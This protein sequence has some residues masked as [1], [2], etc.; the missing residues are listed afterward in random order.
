[1]Y[2]EFCQNDLL[3]KTQRSEVMACARVPLDEQQVTVPGPLG[4][5]RSLPALHPERK[6]ERCFVPYKPPPE[7]GSP[8][9]VEEFL[10]YAR[11]IIEDLEWLLALPHDKFWC[12]VVFDESLQSCLDSYLHHAPRSLDLAAL[13]SSPAVAEMQRSVHKVVFLTFLRM[14]T[15]KESKESFLTPSVFGE[16]IYENFLFD[17][18]KILDL[19]VLFG[20]GNS[21]LLHKM[22]DNI[23]TQQPSYYSDLDETVPTVL[24]VFD[25]V[26]EKCGLHCEGATAM[27]PMKL[28]AH[29][30]PTAMTMSPQDLVDI[31]LYLCDSTTTIHA[32]LDIFPA[33]CAI[34]YSN[35]FL[36]RL[37]SFYETVVPDL[38]NAVKKRNFDDKGLQDDL[39]K[40]LSHSCRKMV[41]MAHLLLHHTCLQPILEGREN[42]QTF[43]EDLL[44]H[45]TS[46]LPEKRFLSDYDEQFPISDDISLL[47]QAVPVIDETRTSYLLQGV[48]SAWESVGR[49]KPPSQIQPK[50][51]QGAAAASS[52][53]FNPQNQVREPGEGSARGAEAMLDAPRK[54]NGVVCPLSEGELESLLSCI[55]DLLPDL[56][57]GFLLA[58]LEAYDYNSELVINNILEDRLT[59]GL[60]KLDRALSRPVKEEI[61]NVLSDRSNV[62]DDDEFDVFRRDQVDMSRIWKGRRK[63]EDPREMLNDKRHIEEQRARY[64]TYETVVDEVVI[65]PGQT[66]ADYGLDDYDDEYDD[67]YDMNQIGANDLDRDSVLNR[68]PF[69]IPQILRRA[70]K[71]EEEEEGE[72]EEEGE[73]LQNNVNRDQFV[74]DPALLRERAEARRAA[75]HQRRGFR[76][77]RTSNVVGQPKGQGQSTDT[78]LDRRKKE[79]NKT[80]VGN[81]NRRS[82]ADRKRNKGMIPS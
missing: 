21:Q 50:A 20:K 46:F 35:G 10:E 74:Q 81:H 19:C 27:E 34:F 26:L 73:P 62:F 64:Q 67:T 30:Q 68:R 37:T 76:P 53:G 56:G 77:E 24:Q 1:M 63:G 22:I 80:R 58:C 7:D 31:L 29:K 57:E 51:N 41:E 2:L 28:N 75:M 40:R 17:I 60:D 65:E 38:E 39:W 25:S 59:P 33:A 18:P 55:S 23:F 44:Q 9:V 32:F 42:M 52:A 49:R 78:F 66:A 4:R 11:F 45:F 61:P 82:M 72:D 47:H 69:T 5:E 16:I 13:P 3:D 14:A 15:H 79:A 43:A 70:N 8:A 36:S 71:P 48:E 12:Q 54:E 6:E